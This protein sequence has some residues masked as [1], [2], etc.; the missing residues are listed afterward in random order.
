VPEFGAGRWR[1]SL[2]ASPEPCLYLVE[3]HEGTLVPLSGLQSPQRHQ[4]SRRGPPISAA[5]CDR[6]A[7]LAQA[8]SRTG[9]G[10]LRECR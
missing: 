9:T 5:R 2:E 4:D 7:E 3:G 8:S 6:I 10:P 1:E